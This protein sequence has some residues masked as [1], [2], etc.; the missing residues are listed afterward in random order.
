MRSN[1]CQYCRW[2]KDA[3]HCTQCKDHDGLEPF[4]LTPFEHQLQDFKRF[5]DQDAYALF[6]EMGVGKTKATID[7]AAYKWLHGTIDKV[8]VIAPNTVHAQ[9]IT[10]EIP[11]HCAV[12]YAAFVY[13]SKHTDKYLMQLSEFLCNAEDKEKLHWLAVHVDAFQYPGIGNVLRRYI[14]SEQGQAK[15]L[16][17]VDEGTRIK[18][19]DTKTHQNL[20]K[21]ANYYG[22][23][24][25]LL[26]GTALAKNPVDTYGMIEFVQPGYWQVGFTAFRRRHAVVMRQK[27]EYTRNGVLREKKVEM[28]L[29]ERL[30]HIV[31]RAI[32]RELNGGVLLTYDQVVDLAQK[33]DLSEADVMFI[34]ESPAYTKF[35]NIEA[36]KAQL[37]PIASMRRK[38]DCVQLPE[39]VYKVIEFDLSPVQKRII[40]QMRDY[41]VA[42][43]GDKELTI[44]QKQTLQIRALQVCGGFFPFISDG[45]TEDKKKYDIEQIKEHNAK[46]E[47]IKSDLEEL[48]GEPFIVWAVFTAE[49]SLLYKELSKTIPVGL[50]YGATDAKVRKVIVERF[51][52]GELQ[53]LIANP[54]VA[55]YG[56][57]LQRAGYQ[58]WYS[59]DYRTEA[60]LQA[61]DRS[62]RIGIVR[63]PVYKDLVYRCAF[64]KKVLEDNKTGRDM[65]DYFNT[66]SVTDLF[67]I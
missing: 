65:N 36:L 41:A 44:A 52:A 27:V 2:L 29:S 1:P 33:Y 10:Q 54:Q 45:S 53:G 22:G 50:L 49:L 14:R 24:R 5:K 8:I 38:V 39:K 11:T 60:R 12:P 63:S 3:E 57:N 23:C 28:L 20:L 18:N 32:A 13:Y 46:L 61:E 19:I 25:T 62:H 4:K 67:T 31:K 59:R 58:Y 55:G 17:V 15:V 35:K 64:E 9:W 42:L 26:T 37:G 66:A 47:Y 21:Y 7:I 40:T 16:W 43:Y 34:H 30:Y 51:L 56:L 6:W 48:S